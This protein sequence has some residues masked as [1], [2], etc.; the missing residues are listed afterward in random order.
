MGLNIN[1][2]KLLLF[3]ITLS[4]ISCTNYVNEMKHVYNDKEEILQVFRNVSV[5]RDQRKDYAFL[6]TYN[7]DKQN[8]Y[9]FSKGQDGYSFERDSILVA[10]DEVLGI[11]GKQSNLDYK[12]QL[13]EKLKFYLGKMDSLSISDISSDFIPQGITLKVY[14]KSKAILVYVANPNNVTNPEWVNYLKSMKKFDEHW[15]YAKQD[16]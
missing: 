14:M 13:N 10:P 16:Q 15:Y 1:A 6:Y 5:F 3:L 4:S 9:I 12:Q 8:Q 2:M 7:N 11:T